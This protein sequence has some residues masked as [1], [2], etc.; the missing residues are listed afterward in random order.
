MASK[1]GVE[2]DARLSPRSTAAEEIRRTLRAAIL[3]GEISGGARLIQTEIAKQLGVSTTPVRE[4]MRA[5]AGDGLITL[6][7][8]RIGTVRTPEREEM[9]EMVEIRRLIDAV[10]IERSMAN[11]TEAELRQARVLAEQLTED[12]DL[13]SWV[14]GNIEFHAVFHSATRTVRLKEIL[15][16]LEEA[17]G[18][19]VAQ[20]QRLDPRIRSTAIQ[21]HFAFL[22]AYAA[23]NADQ[24]V[25]IMH[26]H[27]SLPLEAF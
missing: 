22:D 5:L 10:A 21:E 8:Y 9:I 25:L 3:R 23:G 11:I 4:A 18:V 2:L 12:D 6:D 7:S 16:S 15:L 27:V 26:N 1:R 24:A 14:Q 20:A 13:G 17:A 19:F